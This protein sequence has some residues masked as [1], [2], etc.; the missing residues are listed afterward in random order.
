MNAA[1]NP[2][3]AMRWASSIAN[4]GVL[5]RQNA[6]RKQTSGSGGAKIVYPVVIGAAQRVR[7]IRIINR[8]QVLR[9][10]SRKQ[11]RLI[12]ADLIHICE[13][14]RGDLRAR[15]DFASLFR[16]NAADHFRVHSGPPH[17][18]AINPAGVDRRCRMAVEN[19]RT[20]PVRLLAIIKSRTRR[21]AVLRLQIVGPDFRRLKDMAVSVENGDIFH[22]QFL[23]AWM[24]SRPV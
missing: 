19:Y 17:G 21:H 2:R 10:Q 12:H 15:I 18:A 5:H 23:M 8:G 24:T 14:G 4:E 16:V 9:E 22:R 1:L 13:P 11:Q 7:E 6:Y 3:A 20:H